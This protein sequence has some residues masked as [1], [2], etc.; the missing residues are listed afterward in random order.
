MLNIPVL[1]CISILVYSYFVFSQDNTFYNNF[2][3]LSL[4]FNATV[5]DTYEDSNQQLIYGQNSAPWFTH[6][7]MSKCRNKNEQLTIRDFYERFPSCLYPYCSAM[8]SFSKYF[9]NAV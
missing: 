6:L 2:R 4:I 3:T 7:A 1:I 8:T 9:K 5:Y